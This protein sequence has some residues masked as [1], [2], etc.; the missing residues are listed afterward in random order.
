MEHC[1]WTRGLPLW[2]KEQLTFTSWSAVPICGLFDEAASTFF[3]QHFIPLRH[4]IL[5][6][7][8]D[9]LLPFVRSVAKEETV[10][11]KVMAHLAFLLPK[12]Y[13]TCGWNILLHTIALVKAVPC[14]RDVGHFSWT[15]RIFFYLFKKARCQQRTTARS[16]SELL[17]LVYEEI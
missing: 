13:F 11:T 3:Q 17:N 2:W 15:F 9:L 8:R 6:W 14:L 16:T 12:V 10:N 1:K 7:R 4:N 5:I